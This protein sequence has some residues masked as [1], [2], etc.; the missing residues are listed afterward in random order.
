[1]PYD[2]FVRITHSYAAIA[3]LVSLWAMRCE[4]L[5]VYEHTGE[6]TEKIHCHLLILGS[7]T[8]KK[9]LRNIGSD[10]VDLKGN[11]NCSFKECVSWETP[12]VYMT[13]G[14]LDPKYLKGFTKEEAVEWK[15]K[16]QPR[17]VYRKPNPLASVFEYVF[18]DPYDVEDAQAFRVPKGVL[19]DDVKAFPPTYNAFRMV[20]T[21]SRQM[22]FAKNDDFWSPK[23]ANEHKTMV[24]TYCMRFHIPIPD[25]SKWKEWL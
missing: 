21:R 22:V 12:V 5:A 15:S 9:Q 24:L 13:K 16:W 23:C 8:Q 14:N 10:I 11:E 2:Y 17:N 6:K 3:G 4:K 19:E 7:N 18:G 1:M 25:G 20:V